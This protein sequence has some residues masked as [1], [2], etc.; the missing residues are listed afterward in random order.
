MEQ[1]KNCIPKDLQKGIIEILKNTEAR[2]GK[3]IHINL[4]LIKTPLEERFRFSDKEFCD[5]LAYLSCHGK[6]CFHMKPWYDPDGDVKELAAME[7][8]VALR[9]H[10]KSENKSS[11]KKV[12]KGGRG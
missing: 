6:I 2:E 9:N 5:A 3:V 10:C 11:N 1:I 12:K 4:Y 7:L 8:S